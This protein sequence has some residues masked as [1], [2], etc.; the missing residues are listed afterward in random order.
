[1][2]PNKK[3]P[4][5]AENFVC[6]FC[7]YKCCKKSDYDKHILTRKHKILT[8]PNFFLIDHKEFI[9]E[10][11]KIYKHASSLCAH[12]KKCDFNK[13]ENENENETFSEKMN[14]NILID[15]LLKE[16]KEFKELL[17][18]QNKIVMNMCEKN[19][20]LS[21]NNGN[22]NSHNKTF[23]L[24]VFLNETCKDAM[25][26]MDF[27]NSL[28]LDLSDLEIVGQL[29]YVDGIS[30]I[31]I[32]NLKAMEVHKRPVHCSDSKRE[33][34][35]VKDEDKWE[36]ETENKSKL[37]KA[38]RT[39]AHKNINTIPAFKEKYPDCG[40]SSSRKSD[41]YNKIIIESMGGSG[42]NDAE[43]EEKIIKQIARATVID[44]HIF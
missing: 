5:L 26:I 8:N 3:S 25:N 30:N 10:C 44:K 15:Y 35:Y 24:N 9:C 36:K 40:T 34:I 37:R 32:K 4:K 19:N 43:K 18:E 7:D 1:M 12:K 20:S 27:V 41:I 42:N 33:V 11:G 21:I 29:G 6:N 39:V 14:V 22:I 31:I 38:I 17:L 16:N 23:N 28:K 13:N 2:S